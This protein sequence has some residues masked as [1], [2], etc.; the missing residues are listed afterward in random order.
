MNP[1][2]SIINPTLEPWI[3]TV[4]LALEA[5]ARAQEFRRYHS[6]PHK[7][8][9]VYLNTLAVYAVNVYLQCRGFET[10]LERS[11]SWNPMMQMLM[12]TADLALKDCGKLECRP[13]LPDAEVVC[14]PPEVWEQRMG[15][16]VVQLS[17]SLREATLL[18]FVEK[19]S[20]SKLA[21][22]QLRSLQELPAYLN[23]LNKIKPVVNLSQWF[24][25][26]FEAGWQAV[27]SL[28][29][30]QPTELAFS[31]RGVPQADI[32]RC[33]QIELATPERSVALIVSLSGESEQ[34]MDISVEVQPTNG[35][36]YLPSNL[37]LMVLNEDGEAVMHV[38]AGSDNQTIQLEFGGEAGDRFGV[39]VALGD[40]SVTENFV[41]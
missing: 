41:I 34:D 25:D 6:N 32:R 30:T 19:A 9:Q 15:Y 36:T 26:I 7:A 4:P 11:D 35:Q 5:H 18:G 24:E 21:V 3:F 38:H 14:V 8:K 40:V 16:V 28:L 31:F 20:S 10:N 39:K 37:Q 27:E 12:D 2:Q 13:V 33:K 22:S 29:A 17:E 23:N 1:N